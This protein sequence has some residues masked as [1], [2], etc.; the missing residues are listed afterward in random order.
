MFSRR[1]IDNRKNFRIAFLKNLLFVNAE[2]VTDSDY[3]EFYKKYIANAGSLAN[4]KDYKEYSIGKF[5]VS[6]AEIKNAIIKYQKDLINKEEKV[7]NEIIGYC[8]KINAVV[9]KAEGLE[10]IP[11]SLLDFAYENDYPILI[12]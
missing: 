10:R 5:K 7:H 3:A 6:G 11:K 1:V 12:I 4:F 9:V 8:P 2:D